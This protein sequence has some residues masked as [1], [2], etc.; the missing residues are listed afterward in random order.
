M[1]IFVIV[2][3][4]SIFTLK[5]VIYMKQ[6]LYLIIS[7]ILLGSCAT[8]NDVVSNNIL[9]K[10]KYRQGWNFTNNGKILK[11]ANSE[12][13]KQ[14]ANTDAKI[15]NL[16]NITIP[17]NEVDNYELLDDNAHSLMAVNTEQISDDGINKNHLSKLNF[18]NED[19]CAE[20]IKRD[21]DIIEAKIIEVGV[22]EIKYKKCSNLQ[23]PT[24]NILKSDVFMI[25]HKNGDKD[26]FSDESNSSN[27]SKG[28]GSQKVEPF[29]IVSLI[30][31]ITGLVLGWLISMGAG[32]FL[33]ILGIVFGAISLKKIKRDPSKYSENSAKLAKAGLITGIVI[34]ALSAAILILL[35][36]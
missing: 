28:S 30:T 5:K 31:G 23:G 26:V 9:S 10:R 22:T 1:L 8:S 34:A 11:S 25:K 33:G 15:N 14:I 20:I 6:I 32:V 12:E 17:N 18:N 2:I 36:L 3:I 19:D 13:N 4:K 29:S 24:Y 7:V 16:D 27:N 35:I 21:G